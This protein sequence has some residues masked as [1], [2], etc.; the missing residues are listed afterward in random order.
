[1]KIEEAFSLI[2][3]WDKESKNISSNTSKKRRLN[4]VE[5]TEN[6]RVTRSLVKQFN[7]AYTPVLKTHGP[8]LIQ[9][10]LFRV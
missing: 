1:M 8:I 5:S 10:N 3:S 2:R 7:T 6:S 9:K 4:E